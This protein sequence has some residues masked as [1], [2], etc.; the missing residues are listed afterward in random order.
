[1][2]ELEELYISHNLLTSLS[3]LSTPSSD[4]TT[5][6]LTRV[7]SLRVL[8]ISSNAIASLSDEPRPLTGLTHL[9]E[10]WASDNQL[11]DFREIERELSAKPELKTVYFE[12]NPLQ[13]KGPAVYRNKVRLALPG[14]VQIDAS[15]SP[16]VFSLAFLSLFALLLAGFGALGL[17]FARLYYWSSPVVAVQK[18]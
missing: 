3:G 10:F 13:T 2:P 14:V 5:E 16:L 6:S 18:G 4:T 1:M 17:D 8:D 7:P 15:M 12:G 11:S 9:E